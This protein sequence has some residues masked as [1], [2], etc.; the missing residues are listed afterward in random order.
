MLSSNPRPYF[1]E[2]MQ[3]VVII[4]LL[5][6]PVSAKNHLYTTAIWCSGFGAWK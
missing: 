5:A 3:N 6:G 4:A 2:C 1:H